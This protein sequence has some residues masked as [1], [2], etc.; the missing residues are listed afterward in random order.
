MK[1]IRLRTEYLN[2]PLGI[3]IEKP[4]LMWNCMGALRQ[5]AYEIEVIKEEETWTSGKILSNRMYHDLKEL[6]LNSRDAVT[7]KVRLWDEKDEPGEWSDMA[8]F[9]MG[10][11]SLIIMPLRSIQVVTSITSPFLFIAE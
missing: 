11:F 3:D 5:T 4:R 10:L 7:W 9:E 8:S 6:I 2:N 1:A